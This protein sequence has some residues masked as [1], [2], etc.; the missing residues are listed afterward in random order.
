MFQSKSISKVESAIK[1]WVDFDKTGIIL[2]KFY[3]KNKSLAFSSFSDGLINND[4][5]AWTSPLFLD[6]SFWSSNSIRVSIK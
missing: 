1:K 2:R 3:S 5:F 6:E 4:S